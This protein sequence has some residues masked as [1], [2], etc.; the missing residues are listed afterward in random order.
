MAIHAPETTKMDITADERHA[1]ALFGSGVCVC[2][3]V[4]CVSMYISMYVYMYAC[5]YVRMYMYI[6]VCVYVCSESEP[7][8]SK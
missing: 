4:V 2:V 6:Y 3:C 1:H 8:A 7:V 5:M